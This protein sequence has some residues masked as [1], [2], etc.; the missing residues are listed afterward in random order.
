MN[1][2]GNWFCKCGDGTP[3]TLGNLYKHCTDCAAARDLLE[4]AKWTGYRRRRGVEVPLAAPSSVAGSA[5]EA[6][7]SGSPADPS[8]NAGDEGHADPMDEGMGGA[9]AGWAC[10]AGVA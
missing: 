5:D 2:A 4:A 8:A 9:R 7:P 6:G 1:D 3:R 10:H